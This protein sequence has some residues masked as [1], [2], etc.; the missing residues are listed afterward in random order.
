MS[1][2]SYRPGVPGLVPDAWIVS[3]ETPNTAPPVV[4]VHGIQRQAGEMAFLLRRR[5]VETRRTLIMPVFTPNHWKR[6]QRAACPQRSDLALFALLQALRAEGTIAPGRFDMA[7]FSGGAQFTHRFAWLYPDAVGRLCLAAPGWWTFPEKETAW[8]YGVGRGTV[9]RK[10]IGLT[11]QINLPRF[12]NREI[13]VCVGDRDFARDANLRAGPAIDAQQGPTR[14]ARADRWCKAMQKAADRMG[15]TADLSFKYLPGCGHSFARC[16]TSGR[17]D[18]LF[19]TARQVRAAQHHP[20]T[21]ILE[22]NAA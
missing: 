2:I 10:H 19:V 4:V 13:V 3:P 6:Y 21:P 11:L 17:L 7:G 1:M 22:R 16:A 8:P 20:T 5:A 15:I 12:L 14:V 9:R 18:R